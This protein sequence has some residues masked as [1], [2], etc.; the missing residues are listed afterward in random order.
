MK[1]TIISLFMFLCIS[2]AT[3]TMASEIILTKSEPIPPGPRPLSLV[4]YPVSASIEETSLFV[5]FDWSVGF[6]TITVYDSSNT[7]VYQT[8]VDTSSTLEV[9]IP[10]DYWD[11]D[12]YKLTVSY[13]ATN[14]YGYFQIP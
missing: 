13:G 5:Y 3:K 9:T 11:T 10:V 7:A 2:F 4:S 14:L 12:T 1:R 6:S 8:V